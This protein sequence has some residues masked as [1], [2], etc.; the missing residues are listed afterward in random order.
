MLVSCSCEDGCYEC[1]FAYRN[2]FEQAYT[3]RR[4]A[5][6]ILNAIV[7]RKDKITLS[8]PGLS[9]VK[10]NA[11][12][13]SV[14]EQRFIDALARYRHNDRPTTLRKEVINGKPGYLFSVGEQTWQIE[15]QVELE[16]A[17]TLASEFSLAFYQ[18]EWR[19]VI[20]PNQVKTLKEYLKAPRVGR[21][22]KTFDE[23]VQYLVEQLQTIEQQQN[24][25]SSSCLILRTKSLIESYSKALNAVGIK[26]CQ[27]H[28]SQVDDLSTPG[29]RIAT[30]HR[31]KGLQFEYVLLAGLNKDELPPKRILDRLSDNRARLSLKMRDRNWLNENSPKLKKPKSSINK[32]DWNARDL[33]ILAQAKSAVGNLL[34]QNKPLRITVGRIGAA[35]GLKALLEKHLDK[36][37]I[38]PHKVLT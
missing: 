35:L 26:T 25:L 8:E 27:I 19:D 20:Q 16:Q 4:S 14:L 32:I 9:A 5:I 10:L 34:N 2:N 15:P 11:L 30:M 37:P 17:Y 3:S 22:F 36:L 33:E 23:E 28:R 7:T 12:F 18:D 24:T 29:L 13:D 1:V 38:I 21:G 31:V 6:A